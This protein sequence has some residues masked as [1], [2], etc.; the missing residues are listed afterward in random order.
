MPW[1]GRSRDFGS[2]VEVVEPAVIRE[3]LAAI[4][5]ELCDSVR[6]LREPGKQRAS[7]GES[8][9]RRRPR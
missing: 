9:V 5:S 4:G 6:D 2:I 1:L 3:F 7:E 8:R